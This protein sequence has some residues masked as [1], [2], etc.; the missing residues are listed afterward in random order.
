MRQPSRHPGPPALPRPVLGRRAI[1]SSRQSR[2]D[3]HVA[4]FTVGAGEQRFRGAPPLDLELVEARGTDLST[5]LR[6]HV[7]R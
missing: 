2:L 4:P 5:Y 7:P 6:Y 3:L 1:V